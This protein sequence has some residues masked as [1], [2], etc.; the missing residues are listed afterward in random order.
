MTDKPWPKEW[1]EPEINITVA[2]DCGKV[3][4]FKEWQLCYACGPVSE[5]VILFYR[6]NIYG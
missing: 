2:G 6:K 4:S 5:N 3:H 1:C